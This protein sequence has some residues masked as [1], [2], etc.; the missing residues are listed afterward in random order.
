[1]R[2]EDALR[3]KGRAVPESREDARDTGVGARSREQAQSAAESPRDLAGRAPAERAKKMDASP[4]WR[5]EAATANELAGKVAA[6]APP[7]PPPPASATTP[8]ATTPSAPAPAQSAPAPA[9]QPQLSAG[10]QG[11]AKQVTPERRAAVGLMRASG[12]QAR[13][14]VADRAAAESTVRD[15]V[16][17]AGGSVESTPP[18]L[19]SDAS[20][21]VLMLLVP[22]DR[23][24]EL[25]RGLEAVGKLR[26]TGQKAEDAGQLLITLRLER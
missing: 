25:R 18:V 22:A 14:T 2:P 8:P 12:L 17:R 5:K 9:R 19:Q 24:D 16:T 20:A 13:L 11:V 7:T 21:T 23:W 6:V 3:S 15:L 26:V 1:M 4:E 10:E